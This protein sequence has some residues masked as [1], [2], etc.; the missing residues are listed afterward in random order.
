VEFQ[1]NHSNSSGLGSDAAVLKERVDWTVGHTIFLHNERTS[2]DFSTMGVVIAGDNPPSYS[3]QILAQTSNL[4]AKI[5]QIRH[6]T[7]A[8]DI[9]VKRSPGSTPTELSQPVTFNVSEADNY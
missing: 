7:N 9:I 3:P 1:S 5:A 6:H 2:Y 8:I 4:P